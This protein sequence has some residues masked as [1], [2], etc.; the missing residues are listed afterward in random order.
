LVVRSDEVETFSFFLVASNFPGEGFG[1]EEVLPVAFRGD[2][3]C[4]CWSEY[5]LL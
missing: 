4:I 3:A 1:L 5:N 2:S